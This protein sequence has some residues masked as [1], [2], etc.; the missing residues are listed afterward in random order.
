MLSWNGCSLGS[1][2]SLVMMCDEKIK[3]SDQLEFVVFC[4]ENVASLFDQ[5]KCL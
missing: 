4:I 3:N 1:K 5:I 2:E